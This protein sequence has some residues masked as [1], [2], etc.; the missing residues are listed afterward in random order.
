MSKP[1]EISESSEIS[2]PREIREHGKT[3]ETKS[4]EPREISAPREISVPSPSCALALPG[5][6][7][8]L[9]QETSQAPR[10]V[11]GAN[12]NII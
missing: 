2:K 6:A 8:S 3:S 12:T 5:T 7:A 10:F 9:M 11:V 1:R 4:S